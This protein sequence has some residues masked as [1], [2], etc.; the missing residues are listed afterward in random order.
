MGLTQ[1]EADFLD[2]LTALPS[3]RP[4]SFP[5]KHKEPRTR[6]G[7]N[8]LRLY[9]GS[10]KVASNFTGPP[11]P[12]VSNAAGSTPDPGTN[13]ASSLW[14]QKGDPSY[15]FPPSTLS[16]STSSEPQ[17]N[18]E[19]GTDEIRRVYLPPIS[20]S[21]KSRPSESLP[22]LIPR[23]PRPSTPP[24]SSTYS[25]PSTPPTPSKKTSRG[26]TPFLLRSPSV[27]WGRASSGSSNVSSDQDEKKGAFWTAIQ[28]AGVPIYLGTPGFDGGPMFPYMHG[29]ILTVYLCSVSALPFCTR[30]VLFPRFPFDST[31]R[32][33]GLLS[34][35]RCGAKA[36]EGRFVGIFFRSK[37][38][39]RDL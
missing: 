31:L 26:I 21:R 3:A 17:P 23:L 27:N 14:P 2:S 15:S 30:N 8:S 33:R 19:A 20:P 22:P 24:T 37:E 6:P 25:T 32:Y 1:E 4:L 13:L 10:Y 29:N 35:L 28:A 36:I 38:A 34:R 18:S 9:T 7:S 11:S 39:L 5:L 12:S 16:S